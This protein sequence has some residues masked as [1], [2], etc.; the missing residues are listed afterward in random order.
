[1]SLYEV[2][3]VAALVGVSGFAYRLYRKDTRPRGLGESLPPAS[4]GGMFARNIKN[5]G[6]G[7]PKT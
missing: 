3:V 1:M 5:E 6:G 4:V 2:L 7:S